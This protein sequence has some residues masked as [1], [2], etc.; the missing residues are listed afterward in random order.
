MGHL[1]PGAPSWA[2]FGGPF[3]RCRG[4][5]CRWA[6]MRLIVHS[7][8]HEHMSGPANCLTIVRMNTSLDQKIAPETGPRRSAR[9]PR[10]H[11]GC[12]G[13][14]FRP[15]GHPGSRLGHQLED[16]FGAAKAPKDHVS[17]GKGVHEA[18]RLKFM[19]WEPFCGSVS[20]PLGPIRTV[21]TI[22]E[23][24]CSDSPKAPYLACSWGPFWLPNRT[25]WLL[26]LPI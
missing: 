19:L 11:V 5:L 15:T 9:P 6:S 4:S 2:P 17:C 22:S 3:W 20:T 10:D 21:N 12:P 7:C 24:I 23:S 16:H 13:I 25:Q 26:N 18:C 14:Q 8:A 1:A